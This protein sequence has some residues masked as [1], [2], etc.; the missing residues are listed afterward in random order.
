[1][2]GED[3]CRTGT[4]HPFCAGDECRSLRHPGVE[5]C[6]ARRAGSIRRHDGCFPV[7]AERI[8]ELERLLEESDAERLGLLEAVHDTLHLQHMAEVASNSSDPA[9]LLR[10]FVQAMGRVVPWTAAEVRLRE[11]VADRK[12]TRTALHEGFGQELESEIRELDEEGVLGWA[13][14][15]NRPT[16]LPSLGDSRSCGWLVVPLMVQGADIGFAL[17]RPV[18]TAG[19][20]TAHHLEMVRLIATQTAVALDNIAHID[21][22]RH[23]Y[24]ELRSLHRVAASLGRSLD[25]EDR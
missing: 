9:L 13:L 21:E 1:M 4:A 3:L 2:G 18:A 7:S 19:Q 8:I 11:S 14:E 23:G 12:L 15:T 22:I 10:S 16:L 24:G 25:L 6:G 17:L 5:G 20:L